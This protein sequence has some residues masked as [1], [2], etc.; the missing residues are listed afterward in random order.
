MSQKSEIKFV[1]ADVDFPQTIQKMRA[2]V[3]SGLGM[4]G[5]D[6][7]SGK[8]RRVFDTQ[9]V[10]AVVKKAE[11]K[12]EAEY[13]EHMVATYYWLV[14]RCGDGMTMALRANPGYKTRMR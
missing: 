9:N 8:A 6:V 2:A 4:A 13:F 5:R 14:T 3:P 1:I 7:V 12:K 11:N 10:N